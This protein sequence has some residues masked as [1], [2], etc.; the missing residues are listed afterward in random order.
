MAASAV[1]VA[2]N[3]IENSRADKVVFSDKSTSTSD[4]LSAEKSKPS[5]SSSG[6]DGSITPKDFYWDRILFY[7]VSA[8][9]GLSFLDISVEFFR[10]TALQCFT[11]DNITIR[12]QIAYLNNYCYGSLPNSQY[13]LIFILISALVIIAPHYL[14]MSYFGAHFDFFFDLVKKLNRLRDT[15]IGEYSPINFELV[16]KLEEKFSKSNTWIFRLYKL[17]LVGQLIF[18][19]IVLLINAF[20]FRSDNFEETFL[21]PEDAAVI[22]TPAWPIGSQVTCVYNSLTL[23]LFLRNTALGLVSAAI[24]VILFGLVWCFIRHTTELGAKDIAAF[25]DLSCLPPEDYS[26]P[27]FRK[28]LKKIASCGS[29]EEKLRGYQKRDSTTVTTTEDPESEARGEKS[30]CCPCFAGFWK[31]VQEAFSPRISNDLDFLLM[32]LFSADSGHGQVFKDIQIY[33]ELNEKTSQDH[34]LLYLLNIVHRQLL[35]KRIEKQGT[36]NYDIVATYC[37]KIEPRR[38]SQQ[39]EA[40]TDEDDEFERW[41]DLKKYFFM[42]K[43]DNTN[44]EKQVYS[45]FK[46]QMGVSF[47]DW[48]CLS[49]FIFV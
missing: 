7:L 37:L 21:C 24:L 39:G 42:S 10:Q 9:L 43:F 20:Y 1:A 48:V 32:R 15:S 26:Y 44:P 6:S 23:L 2:S 11:P 8:I 30:V 46:S 27:S 14:W 33:K 4:L 28:V 29:R 5:S 13:Y 31:G 3:V 41:Q 12:D 45:Y 47:K 25:C 36:L 22:D 49:Y 34:E 40:I 38:R 16:K 17:K 18:S 19:L 35:L